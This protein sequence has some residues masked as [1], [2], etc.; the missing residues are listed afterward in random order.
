[1]DAPWT[2]EIQ[3]PGNATVTAG[4]TFSGPVPPP[5]LPALIQ[6]GLSFQ[7]ELEEFGTPNLTT[8]LAM[9]VVESES[10]YCTVTRLTIRTLSLIHLRT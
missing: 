8:V 5:Y 6:S 9:K 3:V 10:M 1:M 4:Q 7:I 2:D